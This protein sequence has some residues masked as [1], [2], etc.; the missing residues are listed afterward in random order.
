MPLS[1]TLIVKLIVPRQ[2]GHLT[3]A[4]HLWSTHAAVNAAIRYYTHGLLDMRG[5]GYETAEGLVAEQTVATALLQRVRKAQ[6][7]NGHKPC[8]GCGDEVLRQH[9]RELYAA[10]VPSAEQAK[11]SAQRA[12]G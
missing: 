2:A 1:R 11:G 6:S 12:R 4:Q 8:E 7:T 9:L 10:M 3:A 5:K